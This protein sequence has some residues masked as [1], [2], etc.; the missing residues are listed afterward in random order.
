MVFKLPFLSFFGLLTIMDNGHVFLGVPDLTIVQNGHAHC[1]RSTCL[2]C[3]STCPLSKSLKP[4][5]YGMCPVQ[6]IVVPLQCIMDISSWVYLTSLLFKNLYAH[7]ANP[8]AH[9]TN[10]GNYYLM[11]C[12]GASHCAWWGAPEEFGRT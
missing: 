5:C 1:L 12:L 3:R 6:A 7:F 8:H 10:H 2:L 11:R 4:L 9:C